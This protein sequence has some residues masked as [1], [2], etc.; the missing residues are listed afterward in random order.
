VP[1]VRTLEDRAAEIEAVDAVGF[2]QAVVSGVS[3][4]GP[5]AMMFAATRPARTRALILAGT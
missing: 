1:K 5:V 4:G 3:D 2:G